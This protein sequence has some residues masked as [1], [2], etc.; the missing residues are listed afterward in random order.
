M[1]GSTLDHDVALEWVRRWDAQ[2]ERYIADREERFR[3]IGDVV[4]HVCRD[5][6][7]PLVADLGCGPGSLT[8]RLRGRVGGRVVGLD[9]DPFLLGLAKAA[10]PEGEY[11]HADLTGSGWLDLVGGSWDAAVS[12]TALHWIAPERLAE[13]YRAVASRLRPGGVLVNGDHLREEQPALRTLAEHVRDERARRAGVVG[14]EDWRAWWEA[15]RADERLTT[16]FTEEEMAAKGS[17]HGNGLS[18]RQ[19]GELLR[20]AGFSEVGTVWQHGDDHV[21]VAVR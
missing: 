19:H 14:N 5:V 9:A 6:T 17:G 4:A 20:A 11:E 3:V 16:V 18:A 10:D 7:A 8:T 2:Q 1:T 13:V 21:L 15:A 12:T